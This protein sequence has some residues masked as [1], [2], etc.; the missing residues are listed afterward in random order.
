[1][2]KTLKWILELTLTQQLMVIILIFTISFCTFFFL[3][4]GRNID[5]FVEDQMFRI[6]ELSQSDVI[7]SYT[8]N[9]PISTLVKRQDTNM[10]HVILTKPNMYII[11]TLALDEHLMNRMLSQAADQVVP[12]VRYSFRSGGS[13]IYYMIRRINS[14]E[15]FISYMYES[16]GNQ[17][18]DTLLSNIINITVFVVFILFILLLL[19]VASIIQPLKQIRTYIDRLKVGQRAELRIMRQ[20]E[21]GDLANALVGMKIEMDYQES[22]KNE[23][24]HNIS[25]DLKTPIATIKSYGE[26]IKDGIY[27]Y[28]TLEKSVDVIIEHAGRLEKKVQSL[29]LL[30]RLSYVESEQI[31][32]VNVDMAAVIQQVLLAIKVIKPNIQIDANLIPC[33][34]RGN[35]ENWRVAVENI[36][37]NA[38]RYARTVIRISLKKDELIIENDGPSISEA[39][40]HSIF[41][42]YEKGTDGNFGLGLSIVY[43]IVTKFGYFVVA[44]NYD[45]GVRFRIYNT[46]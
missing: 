23:L 6:L 41:K 46:K 45:G 19:W 3:L 33:T 17:V 10:G 4:L 38:L 39:S 44:E 43:K 27:P 42:A 9:I 29:L 16:L 35:E 11:G 13:S 15:I 1:M 21:I 20:D 5:E 32:M 30:N 37:D 26:S 31:E 24:I 18:R 34:F 28:D 25:H 12:T 2:K 22:L 36:I 14:E 7:F 40:L 8:Q